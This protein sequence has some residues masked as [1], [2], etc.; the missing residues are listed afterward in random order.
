MSRL[1]RSLAAHLGGLPATFWWLWTG[2]LVNSLA[3]FVFPFLALYLTSRGLDPESTGLILSVFGAG[4][5]AAGPAAGALSDRVGRRPT[6]LAALIGS[7]IAAACLGFVQAPALVVLAVLAFGLFCGMARP[8]LAATVSDVV[9]PESRTRAFGLLYWATNLG[10]G[11]SAVVGGA[12][13]SRSWLGLFLADAATTAVFA[14]L[15]WRRVPETRPVP[16]MGPG[17][18]ARGYATL[19]RDRPFLAFFAVQLAFLLVFLQFGIALPIAMARHG[20]SPAQYGRVIAVNCVLIVLVQPWAGRFLERFD[21]A[22][23]MALAALLVGTG[24]GAYRPCSTELQFALATAVWSLGE[25]AGLPTAAAVVA[26]LAPADLRGRYQGMYGLSLGIS[27]M[28]APIVGGAMLQR[29]GPDALW[30][31]CFAAGIAVAAAHLYIGRGRPTPRGTPSAPRARRGAP[32]PCPPSP[33]RPSPARRPGAPAG[34][35]CGRS[36]RRGGGPLPPR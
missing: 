32:G 26:D 6:I 31:A 12:I 22:H 27:M 21:R 1:R 16:A 23:V 35:P 9:A 4:A 8:S 24:Y 33:P 5:M 11:F 20:L 19:L 2:A 30:S 34:A 29:F 13:A 18:T 28:A 3:S 15:L 14:L 10:F 7:A 25:I 17:A 36:A